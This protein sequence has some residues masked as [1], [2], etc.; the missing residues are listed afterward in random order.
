MVGKRFDLSVEDA[1]CLEKARGWGLIALAIEPGCQLASSDN[2]FPWQDPVGREKRSAV[3][4]V[5]AGIHFH[6][7]P[8]IIVPWARGYLLPIC[9]RAKLWLTP[10]DQRD[11]GRQGERERAFWKALSIT[12]IVTQRLEVEERGHDGKV[13]RTAAE[14]GRRGKAYNNQDSN[15][16]P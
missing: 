10:I 7:S 13:R 1:I 11:S 14:G 8:V 5:D 12:T 16:L 3:W 6:R 2:C 9:V 15:A 4:R